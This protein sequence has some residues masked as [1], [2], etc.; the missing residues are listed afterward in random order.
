MDKILIEYGDEFYEEF[1]IPEGISPYAVRTSWMETTVN[2]KG[3]IFEILHTDEISI[4]L[5]T[6]DA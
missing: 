3:T 4:I 5:E 1:E 6:M 2:E